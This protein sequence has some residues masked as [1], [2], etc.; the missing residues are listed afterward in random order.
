[1][2]DLKEALQLIADLAKA[3]EKPNI[4]E[5]AQ[6]TYSDKELTP[7][8]EPRPERITAST[9]KGFV[10]LIGAKVEKFDPESVIVH[11]VDHTVVE[12]KA[13]TSDKWGRRQ[14]F[15]AAEMPEIKGLTFDQYYDHEA[16]MIALQVNFVPNEDLERLLRL[17]STIET[18]ST[19]EDSGIAQAVA[20]RSRPA[21]LG[22]KP[23]VSLAPF[24]TFRDVA[25][26]TSDFIF[27]VKQEGQRATLALFEADGGKWKLDAVTNI[28]AFLSAALIAA[29]G[30]ENIPIVS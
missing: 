19:S 6:R 13:T 23:R 28:R 26:P 2:E 29:F 9:L 27:R 1:M 3:A 15:A 20:Q 18:V 17:A 10:D 12:L 22:L 21:Q 14:V 16:F 5:I 11:I 30:S 24:R 4:T 7:V 25:Q 8:K